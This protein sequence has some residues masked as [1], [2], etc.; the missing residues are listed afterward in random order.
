MPRTCIDPA[1]FSGHANVVTMSNNSL[2]A[3]QQLQMLRK[4]QRKSF[5]AFGSVQNLNVW[6]KFAS[7]HGLTTSRHKWLLVTGDVT[8]DVPEVKCAACK[9]DLIL[10]QPVESK[11]WKP[12]ENTTVYF[13]TRIQNYFLFDLIRLLIEINGDFDTFDLTLSN[14]MHSKFGSFEFFKQN[15]TAI[16]FSDISM[17]IFN[18]SLDASKKNFTANPIADY[19]AAFP[20]GTFFRRAYKTTIVRIVTHEVSYCCF[21]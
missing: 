14:A 17:K 5:I 3:S 13:E 10:A 19:V 2:T 7:K 11:I 21:V 18:L 16:I 15:S 6:L 4:L 1:S 12:I 9:S 20:N 8:A